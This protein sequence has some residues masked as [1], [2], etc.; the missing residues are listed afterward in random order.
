MTVQVSTERRTM[1]TPHAVYRIYHADGSLLY[2]GV[3]WNPQQRLRQH[4]GWIS[5]YR[6]PCRVTLTWYGNR[7]AAYDAEAEAIQAEQPLNN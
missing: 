4:Q 7:V 6:V 5:R 2:I 3:T 1:A